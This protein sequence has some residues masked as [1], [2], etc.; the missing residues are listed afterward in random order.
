MGDSAFE[1]RENRFSYLSIAIFRVARCG[2]Y[3]FKIVSGL[4]QSFN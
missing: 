3:T 1:N 4:V 2:F